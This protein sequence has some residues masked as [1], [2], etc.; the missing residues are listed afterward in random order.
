MIDCFLFFNELD[1]LEIRLNAL[2]PYVS[3]FV[4][5]E[6]PVTHT[7]KPKSLYFKKQRSRFSKF[8][9]THLI[10]EG[11]EKFLGEDPW[12]LENY[13]REYL[14]NGIAS[15]PDNEF[16]LLSD[17][18][19]IPN[20]ENFKNQE[21]VFRQKLYYYYFNVY[22]GIDKWHGT[23][24]IKKR[25]AKNLNDIRNRRNRITP[26]IQD[27]GWHFSTLAPLK[28]ILQKLESFAHTEFNTEEHRKRMVDNFTFLKDPYNR[29][30]SLVIEDPS[31]PEWLLE[32]KER[33]QHLWL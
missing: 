26:M 5:C 4:L 6:C 19:E 29:N 15:V 27:G 12:L 22:S 33:Y 3:R 31:G 9:I 21:C 11:Y 1:L 10:V 14:Q 13:Q 32:N 23:I 7:G 8:N 28:N 17:I 18:D 2:K 24:A 16:I 25:H 30:N 20:L